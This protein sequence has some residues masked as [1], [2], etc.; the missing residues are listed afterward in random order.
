MR[1]MKETSKE[2]RIRARMMPGAITLS[3]FI[4][5]DKRSLPEIVA[6]DETELLSLQRT[7]EELADR[8]QYFTEASFNAY[9][10]KILVEEIYEVET[11]VTRG[12]LPCPYAHGGSYRKSI[13]RLTNTKSKVSV[14]WTTLNI[15]LIKDHHFFEGKGSSFRLE[16]ANLVKAL[17]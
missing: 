11:E 5:K 4:G 8:M 3:G 15:H 16:P 1:K 9:D 2:I 6:A 10:G 7:A 13:T 17:Y 12:K 14:V